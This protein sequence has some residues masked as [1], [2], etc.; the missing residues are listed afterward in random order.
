MR[1]FYSSRSGGGLMW[2]VID[3]K[4]GSSRCAG[5][6]MTGLVTPD[7]ETQLFSV[8]RFSFPKSFLFLYFAFILSEVMTKEFFILWD[9]QCHTCI[10]FASSVSC[11]STDH[12]A[13]FGGGSYF[14]YLERS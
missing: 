5:L 6:T 2:S 10:R 1:S 8:F 14:E 3:D 12:W 4:T 13:I 9:P 7:N 11:T